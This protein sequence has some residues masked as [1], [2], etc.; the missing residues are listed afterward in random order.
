[1]LKIIRKKYNDIY[2]KYDIQNKMTKYITSDNIKIMGYIFILSRLYKIYNGVIYNN[3][4][5]R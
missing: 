3:K 4:V 5:F 1:M 2:K